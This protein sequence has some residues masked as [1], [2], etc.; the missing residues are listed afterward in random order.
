MAKKAKKKAGSKGSAETPAEKVTTSAR[1]RKPHL[2][3]LDQKTRNLIKNSSLQ[4]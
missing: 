4:G 1:R 3:E 2:D